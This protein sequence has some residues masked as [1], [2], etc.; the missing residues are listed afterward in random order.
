MRVAILAFLALLPFVDAEAAERTLS[1]PAFG[2]SLRLPDGLTTCA[3]EPAAPLHGWTIPLAGDCS[4]RGRRISIFAEWNATFS[5]SI[6]DAV[7]CRDESRVALKPEET[8]GLTLG[9]ARSV[10]CGQRELNGDI[11]VAVATQAGEW[12]GASPGDPEFTTPAVNYYVYLR[13]TDAHLPD[14]LKTFK[15][16]LKGV[17]LRAPK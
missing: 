15:R 8:K 5:R 6:E 12:H 4:A 10:V 7:D 1:A 9:A 11:S 2:L 17:A 16:A 14:D 3:H 13:T